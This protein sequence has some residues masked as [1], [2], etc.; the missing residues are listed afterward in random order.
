MTKVTNQRV[1]NK[2]H[3]DLISSQN[4]SSL[5][6][7]ENVKSIECKEAVPHQAHNENKSNNPNM[8]LVFR[9]NQFKDRVVNFQKNRGKSHNSPMRTE[10]TSLERLI[11]G[12]KNQQRLKKLKIEKKNFEE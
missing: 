10:A 8:R 9:Q 11:K 2:V 6:Q 7:G 12:M 4:G 5:S 1:S 3:S